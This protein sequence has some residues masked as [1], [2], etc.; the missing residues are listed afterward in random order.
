MNPNMIPGR[1]VIGQP[2]F[3]PRFNQTFATP[4]PNGPLFYP[5]P[6]SSPG[7]P[8]QVGGPYQASPTFQYQPLTAPL[9]SK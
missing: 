3:I 1:S 6:A 2:I 4:P 8:Y 9:P 5:Q 7:V